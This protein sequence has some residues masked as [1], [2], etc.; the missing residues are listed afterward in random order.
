MKNE[1]K[2]K[3]KILMNYKKEIDKR[4]VYNCVTYD[5]T[6]LFSSL[7]F[8]VISLA[9]LKTSSANHFGVIY[10]ALLCFAV[11]IVGLLFSSY[12]ANKA[13][14]YCRDNADQ[15]YENEIE[16]EKSNLRI[17]YIEHLDEALGVIFSIGVILVMITI[18]LN[19]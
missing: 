9:I 18:F 5:I 19:L 11:A 13:I 17:K 10:V 7:I 6:I 14:S 8:F 15:I 1:D 3:A 2:E 12:I 16:Y 4:Y